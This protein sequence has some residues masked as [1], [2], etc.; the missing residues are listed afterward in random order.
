MFTALI[1]QEFSD[2]GKQI[3]AILGASL[4]F[5]LACI[6]A[7]LLHLPVVS[8]F[9][10]SALSLLGAFVPASV[11][12]GLA[13]SYWRTMH[14]P[15]GYFTHAIPVRGCELYW[16]KTLFAY[17]AGLIALLLGILSIGS[18]IVLNLVGDG[19]TVSELLREFVDQMEALPALFV[20]LGV[21]GVL[22]SLAALVFPVASV[23][24]IGA[25]GRWNRHGFAAPAIG[26]VLLYA[27]NQI[28]GFAGMLFVPGAIDVAT[29]DFTWAT[30]L[31]EFIEAV[32]TGQ[33]AKVVGLGMIP[34]SALLTTA[35]IV[36]GIRSIENR[37]SLR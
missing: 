32:R 29:G 7:A 12:L 28:A 10:R 18:G 3:G 22:L 14:G 31:P 27:V 9:A 15:R 11:L 26:L 5:V 13:M 37:T 1:R 30:M 33:D 25:E 23:M 17:V 4:V 8:G 36:W 16:A 24:S 2:N 20:W 21:V 19:V 35:M 6:G 34:M